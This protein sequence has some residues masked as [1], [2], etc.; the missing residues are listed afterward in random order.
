MPLKD[1]LYDAGQLQLQTIQYHM[2]QL[3]AMPHADGQPQTA[4]AQCMPST[5]SEWPDVACRAEGELAL[6]RRQLEAARGEAAALS[7]QLAAQRAEHGLLRTQA[8]QAE[9]AAAAAQAELASQQA[10]LLDTAAKVSRVL[11]SRPTENDCPQYH[12]LTRSEFPMGLQ[13]RALTCSLQPG[14]MTVN[15]SLPRQC[16]LSLSWHFCP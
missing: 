9:Q 11:P 2:G 5:G 1:K 15:T 13:G 7:E 6:G 16:G 8:A 14:G 4:A 12:S 10:D 3:K